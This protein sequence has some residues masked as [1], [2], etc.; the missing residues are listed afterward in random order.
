LLSYATVLNATAYVFHWSA[1]TL[2]AIASYAVL[3]G[4]NGSSGSLQCSSTS[5]TAFAAPAE[6]TFDLSSLGFVP[7]FSVH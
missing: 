4:G 5:S 2:I 1:G 7:P 6:S 3:N